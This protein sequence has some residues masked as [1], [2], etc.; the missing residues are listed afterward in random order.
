MAEAAVP[1]A[2]DSEATA[3]IAR[4]AALKQAGNEHFQQGR[5]KEAMIAYHQV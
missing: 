3:G 2:N 1:R 4:A 5:F